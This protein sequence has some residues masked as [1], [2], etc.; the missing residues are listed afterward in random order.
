MTSS[1]TIER[2]AAAWLAR[3]DASNWGEPEQAQFDAWLAASTHHRVA[4]LRLDVAWRQS[5]RLHALGAGMPSGIVP[6]RRSWSFSAFVDRPESGAPKA[7]DK[8]MP[9]GTV[10]SA[11]STQPALRQRVRLGAAIAALATAVILIVIWQR[12]PAVHHSTYQTAIGTLQSVTLADGSEATLNS[13]SDIVVDLSRRERD[14]D[15]RRGE[16]FFKVAKNPHRPFVVSVGSHRAIA[17]GT[18]FS[19]RRQGSGLRVIVTEGVVR[20]E[21]DATAGS[22]HQAT[23]LLPAGSV[24]EVNNADLLVRQ[25]GPEDAKQLLDWRNGFVTFDDTALASAVAQFN[26]YNRIKIVISDP[27][28]AAMRISGNFRWSNGEAFVRLLE[29]G[30]ALHAEHDGD[31]IVLQRRRNAAA[32]RSAAVQR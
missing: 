13:D 11:P 23:T 19:V 27:R 1:R 9:S 30:F 15:L 5:D 20:L 21:S 6:P 8:Q 16:A 14:I 28:V 24:A 26:R 12:Y 25:I 7:H 32:Q 31:T 4:Y 3:R 2:I 17:V 10:A 22:L 18:R 29:Q